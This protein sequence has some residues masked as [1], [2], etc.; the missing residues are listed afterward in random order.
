MKN[1][2]DRKMHMEK[3]HPDS[4]AYFPD[5]AHNKKLMSPREISDTMYP[6]TSE[7]IYSDQEQAVSA[8]DKGK[9]APGFRH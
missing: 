9:L 8:S 4:E 6:D 2:N 3:G 5:Y 1:M 7:Y